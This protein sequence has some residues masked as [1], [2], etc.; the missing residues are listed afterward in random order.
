MTTNGL[1]RAD[2]YDVFLNRWDTRHIITKHEPALSYS[3]S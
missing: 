3:V 1:L 2:D